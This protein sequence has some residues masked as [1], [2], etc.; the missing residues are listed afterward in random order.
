MRTTYLG[1]QVDHAIAEKHGG[2]AESD[3]LCLACTF[4]NR[5]KGT[6]IGSISSSTGEFIRFFIPRKDH[7]AD[8]FWLNGVAVEPRTPIGDVTAK[9][10]GFNDADRILERRTVQAV[11]RY[12]PHAAAALLVERKVE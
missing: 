8:H 9:I 7:W 2:R 6:D 3:N 4:C 1:C 10:L 5:A 12:P 11:G